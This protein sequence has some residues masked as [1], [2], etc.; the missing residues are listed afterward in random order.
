MLSRVLL[1]RGKVLARCIG[2]DGFVAVTCLLVGLISL[3][4]RRLGGV[5]ASVPSRGI[6][7][8]LYNLGSANC[9]Y[10]RII[11]YLIVPVLFFIAGK[12]LNV[13]DVCSQDWGSERGG[14]MGGCLKVLKTS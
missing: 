11:S 2:W 10:T 8:N 9:P 4:G 6:G 7:S 12:P 14:I 13:R 1:G 3:L 5:V